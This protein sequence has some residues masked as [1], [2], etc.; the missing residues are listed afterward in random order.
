MNKRLTTGLA[1]LLVPLLV[2]GS[3]LWGT[4][5]AN[6]RLRQVEA[7]VVN[8]DEMVEVG[9]QMMPLGRQLAAELVNSDREQNFTWVLADE[10]KAH[11]GC[12]GSVTDNFH[13]SAPASRASTPTFP[14]RGWQEQGVRPRRVGRHATG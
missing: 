6:P 13:K 11:E 8:N 9:G 3:L 1:V 10:A 14:V 12:D 7:A 2:A 5:N 4:W